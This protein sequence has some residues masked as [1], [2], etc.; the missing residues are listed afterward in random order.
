MKFTGVKNLQRKQI[1]FLF[2]IPIFQGHWKNLGALNVRNCFS[3]GHDAGGQLVSGHH[4]LRWSN[5]S[6]STLLGLRDCKIY[7]NTR[8]D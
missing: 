2:L 6:I 1:L 8:Q 5:N 3:Y 4:Y 7:S